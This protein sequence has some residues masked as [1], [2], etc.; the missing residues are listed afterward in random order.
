MDLKRR[1]CFVGLTIS[2]FLVVL[3]AF[4]AGLQVAGIADGRAGDPVIGYDWLALDLAFLVVGLFSTGWY[5]R[6][7]EDSQ[8]QKS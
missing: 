8:C 3:M 2:Q 6:K 5:F 7:A 4:C 1:A